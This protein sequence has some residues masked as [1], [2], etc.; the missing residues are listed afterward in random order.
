[1]WNGLLLPLAQGFVSII[2]SALLHLQCYN[3][4][5]TFSIIQKDI[6][7]P[8]RQNAI[9][10]MNSFSC[11]QSGVKLYDTW[12]KCIMENYLWIFEMFYSNLHLPWFLSI[13]ACNK[14]LQKQIWRL[15][16]ILFSVTDALISL[17]IFSTKHKE[18][19]TQASLL[20]PFLLY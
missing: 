14:Y 17:F 4:I 3:F 12:K 13:D 5:G 10:I 20:F 6:S 19:S 16:L 8:S 15:L 18:I 2:T 1:M 7:K 9:K 11:K